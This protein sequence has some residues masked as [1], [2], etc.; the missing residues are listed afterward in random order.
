MAHPLNRPTFSAEQGRVIDG[1]G[2]VQPRITPSL[3]T[4]REGS[5]FQ[6]VF[7]RAG[8]IDPYAS[9]VSDA[10]PGP[11]SRRLLH[12]QGNLRPRHFSKRHWLTRRR[13][14]ILLSHDLFEGIFAR[15]ALAT[16]IEL[17]DEFPF[18]L[19]G[20]RCPP[21]PLGA[22]DWQLLAWIIGGRAGSRGGRTFKVPVIGR[23]RCLTTSGDLFWPVHVSNLVGWL[24]VAGDLAWLWTRFVLAMIIFP[25][26]IPFLA[27][28]NA[29]WEEFRNGVT[30]AASLRISRWGCPRRVWRSRFSPTKPLRWLTP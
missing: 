6:R 19:R 21:I 13:K 4:D 1:Y 12:R 23:G 7:F 8:G 27:G 25:A 18:S 26:L 28:I 17:F 15:S 2:I 5:L 9:S 24:A 10:V 14:N 29:H 3:P 16:D 11:V 30:S 20:R 22:G